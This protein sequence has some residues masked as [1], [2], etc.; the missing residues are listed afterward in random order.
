MAEENIHDTVIS[1]SNILEN[2]E[3]HEMIK[4]TPPHIQYAIKFWHTS[5]CR[6][7]TVTLSPSQIKGVYTVNRDMIYNC[8]YG[9]WRRVIISKKVRYVF[10]FY[11]F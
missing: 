6:V 2:D 5:F 7:C 1:T 4:K 9:G 10:L 11:C 3:I 8:I